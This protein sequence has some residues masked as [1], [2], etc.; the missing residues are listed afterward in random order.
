MPSAHPSS[1][2]CLSGSSPLSADPAQVPT[3]EFPAIPCPSFQEFCFR[4]KVFH[5][6]DLEL[7]QVKAPKSVQ[8]RNTYVQAQRCQSVKDSKNFYPLKRSEL[9]GH[10]QPKLGQKTKPSHKLS[11]LTA[12]HRW[13][14][15]GSQ[16]GLQCK[17][18][19]EH[20]AST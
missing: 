12:Q 15:D 20:K 14:L 16:C 3:L 9:E 18:S 19:E 7:S 11:N 17:L 6:S 4:I 13:K 5:G 1:L 10:I 2:I 8:H